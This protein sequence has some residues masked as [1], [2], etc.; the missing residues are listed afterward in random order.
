MVKE[1]RN[2][3]RVALDMNMIRYG[4]ILELERECQ[5]NKRKVKHFG[6]STLPGIKEEI[7]QLSTILKSKP[8]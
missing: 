8:Q 3:W 4:I 1:R 5:K 2:V 7:S 6:G